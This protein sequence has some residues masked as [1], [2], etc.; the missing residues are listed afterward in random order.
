MIPLKQFIAVE[1]KRLGVCAGSV[2]AYIR[3]GNYIGMKLHRKNERVVFVV[4]PGIK[5]E[6]PPKRIG[7]SRFSPKTSRR[8]W[9]GLSPK[10]IGHTAHMREWRKLRK[11]KAMQTT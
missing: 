5:P 3:G 2:Y 8:W 11:Q 9:T 6:K 1:A 4:D 7:F 10:R